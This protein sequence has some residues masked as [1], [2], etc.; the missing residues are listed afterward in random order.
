[1]Y[2]LD[3]IIESIINGQ[4]RQAVVQI[5]MSDITWREVFDRLEEMD[6]PHEI[7][8]MFTIGQNMEHILV[9]GE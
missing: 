2:E 6:R 4:R 8:V 9:R 1:M 7:C 3:D 5:E